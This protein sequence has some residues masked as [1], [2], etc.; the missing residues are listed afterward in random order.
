MKD[1]AKEDVL[2]EGLPIYK[3][4]AQDDQDSVRL[5]TVQDLIIIAKHL[6]PEEV[7]SLLLKQLAQSAS[8]KSWRVRYMVANDFVAVRFYTS[9][10]VSNI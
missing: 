8:D 2:A 9:V 3:R 4:L 10:A 6:T 7:E 5:L 1:M